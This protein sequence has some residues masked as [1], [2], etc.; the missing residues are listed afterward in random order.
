MRYLTGNK[1]QLKDKKTIRFILAVIPAVCLVLA[2]IIYSF[3]YTADRGGPDSPAP[4]SA[5][6]AYTYALSS[7][8]AAFSWAA[9]SFD[10]RHREEGY[11]NWGLAQAIGLNLLVIIGLPL[12]AI[13]FME[14]Q[15]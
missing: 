9:S 11:R 8:D 3:R 10:V 5:D 1:G 7:T 6:A 2:V 12:A 13:R 4:L 14:A 15:I